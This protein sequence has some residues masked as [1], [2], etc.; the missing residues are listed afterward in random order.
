MKVRV[1]FITTLLS[2]LLYPFA[3]WASDCVECHIIKTPAAVQQWQESAHAPKIGCEDCHGEDHEAI[4]SGRSPVRARTCGRC[5]EKVYDEH[6]RSKHGMGLHA[7]WGCT[8][9]LNNRDRSEC[10]FCHEDGSTIP[11]TVVQCAR[12]LTQTSEMGALGCNRCHQ[13]ESSCASCHTNHITSLDV[14]RDPASCATCHMGPDHPQWE[15][16]QTSRHGIL[17]ASLGESTGPSCK[18]CHM[19]QGTHDVSF[20][21]TMSPAMVQDD[22]YFEQ[23]REEMTGI[24][25]QCHGRSFVEKEL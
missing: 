9:N 3:V 18:R 10:L 22:E 15:M 1:L 4:L 21:I 23:R 24:C 8:R 2:I 11:K 14:V 16:W 6:S 25:V 19:P 7:G 20:G 12:F 17:F 13:V 5:H